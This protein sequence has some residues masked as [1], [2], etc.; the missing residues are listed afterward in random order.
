MSNHFNGLTPAE[1][2]RLAVLAEECAEVI[3]IISKIQRHGYQSYDPTKCPTERFSNRAL[4]EKELGD[5]KFAT[6]LLLTANDISGKEVDVWMQKK[7]KNLP[8]YLHHQD[9]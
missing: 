3:H 8:Q 4:L 5:V 6:L 1:A 9:T 2:E 7:A